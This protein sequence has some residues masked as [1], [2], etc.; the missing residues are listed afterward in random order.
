[1]DVEASIWPIHY[2]L[3][4]K[5]SVGYLRKTLWY[6]NFRRREFSSREFNKYSKLFRKQKSKDQNNHLFMRV[7]AL[8]CLWAV[9]LVWPKGRYTR[10]ILLPEHAP[11][12]R[13]GS[14]APP[15]VPTI[16]WVYF[17]LGSRISTPQNAP[18]YLT[19]LN[20]WEK[21]PGEIERTWKRSLLC[22]D[23]CKMSLEHAPGAKALVCIGLNKL[24][25]LFVCLF[26]SFIN[27]KLFGFYR[28][29]SKTLMT[30]YPDLWNTCK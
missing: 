22:T 15:C 30:R 17:I 10:G 9:F 7:I 23:R 26:V 1:M 5:R 27:G 4:R 11:G 28:P 3:Q 25:L 12:A 13:S 6:W 2:I 24:C 18:R 20:I 21:D 14:K 16:S 19:G 29:I 8:P